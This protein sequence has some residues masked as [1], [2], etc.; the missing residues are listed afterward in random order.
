MCLPHH[1]EILLTAS[2]LA[3]RKKFTPP[4]DAPVIVRSLDYAG[5]E[6]PA[7]NKRVI[8][9]AVSQLPLRGEDA[10]HKI[11]LIAGPRWTMKP[12]ADGG[13]ATSEDWGEGYIK[14]SCEDCPTPAMNLKKASDILDRL[15][16]AANVCGCL[17]L[18]LFPMLTVPQD[19]NANK[20]RKVPLDL[21]HIYAKA[22][23]AKKGEHLRSRVHNRPTLYDFPEEWLPRMDELPRRR[24]VMY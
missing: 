1:S 19:P 16:E 2:L 5:E 12:P 6:H 11:K 20:F 13:V 24:S 22:R 10:I 9:V 8:V 3:H 23:K 14:I 18:L 15:I 21:R 17:T 7:T 4:K